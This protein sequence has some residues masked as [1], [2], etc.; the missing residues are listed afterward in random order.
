MG[1][2]HRHLRIHGVQFHP[3]V[4]AHARRPPDP[5]QLP[6]DVAMFPALIEKLASARRPHRG[7]GG[8][9][10]GRHHEGRGRARADRRAARRPGDE[11]R[12]ALGTRGLRPDDAGERRGRARH[13]GGRSSTRAAPAAT[14]RASFNISTAAAIVMAACGIARGQAWQP[15]GRRASAAARTCSRRSACNIQASPEVDRAVP[16]RSRHRLLLRAH[17]PSGDAA[18]RPGA[19]RPRRA[20]GVQPARAAHQSR[21]A[22]PGR[23]SACR[24]PS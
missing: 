21:A 6:R 18:R 15:L 2:R 9:G 23:S 3:G 5:P 10:D 16:G 12:A 22:R 13:R 14:A 4:G 17:V 11:G 24:G 19:P 20:N 8:G 7:R 1:L